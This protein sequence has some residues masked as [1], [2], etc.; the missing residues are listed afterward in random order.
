MVK[1]ALFRGKAA[2]FEVVHPKNLWLYFGAAL[3]V[4][5]L[6]GVLLYLWFHI[7][8]HIIVVTLQ[9]CACVAGLSVGQ[10]SY[11]IFVHLC[12]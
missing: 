3:F 1:R 2:L 11:F 7:G 10:G 6:F 4:V 5:A 9:S 12:L 8:I